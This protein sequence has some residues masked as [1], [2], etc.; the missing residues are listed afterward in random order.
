MLLVPSDLRPL[1]ARLPHV[2]LLAVCL[3]DTFAH[4]ATRPMGAAVQELVPRNPPHTREPPT[5]PGLY[6]QR[7]GSFTPGAVKLCLFS[8]DDLYHQIVCSPPPLLAGW[9]P[10]GAPIFIGEMEFINKAHRDYVFGELGKNPSGG[11]R[12]AEEAQKNPWEWANGKVIF[13]SLTHSGLQGGPDGGPDEERNGRLVISETTMNN[14]W[15]PTLLYW[16]HGEG[17]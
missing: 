5:E 15:K 16:T 4:V 10:T 8:M 17:E 13:L 14:N 2:L 1:P 12:E 3:L 9:Y 11:S 7:Y 6:L